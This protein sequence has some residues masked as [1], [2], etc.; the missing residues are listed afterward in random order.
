M[1]VDRGRRTEA[2][3]PDRRVEL[4][5]SEVYSRE[6]ATSSAHRH[7]PPGAPG[8]HVARRAMTSSNVGA[9]GFS[10]GVPSKFTDNVVV[11]NV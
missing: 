11:I 8:I 9:S 3:E 4:W 5:P 1:A 2:R 10:F 7:T 6:R